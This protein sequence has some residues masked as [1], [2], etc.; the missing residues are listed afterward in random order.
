MSTSLTTSNPPYEVEEV[1]GVLRMYSNGSIVRSAKSLFDSPVLDDSFI[2]S[3]EILFDV[4][5]NLYLRLYKPASTPSNTKLPVFYYIPGGGFC[6]RTRMWSNFHNDCIRLASELQAVVIAPDYRLASEHRLPA[7]IDDAYTAVKWLK[8]QAVSENPYAWLNGIADFGRVFISGD[9]A[10]A[11]I[12]HNLAVRICA[13]SNEL[14]P[15]IVRGYV[16]LELFLVGPSLRRRRF[17]RLSMPVG[18]TK[19]HTLVNPFGPTSPLMETLELGPILVAVG[20]SDLLKDQVKDYASKLQKWGKN[21]EFVEYEDK[22]HGFFTFDPNCEASTH[23]MQL[24]KKF[25]VVNS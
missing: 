25:V 8:D 24:I 13:G 20:I 4:T 22:Q 10:G 2:L 12:A 17:W 21:I 15:V 16:L 7:A 1:P 9:S 14:A 11:N 19:D 23:F 18:A 3:K 5:N 6:I